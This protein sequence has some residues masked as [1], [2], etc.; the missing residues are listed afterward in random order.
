MRSVLRA[1]FAVFEKQYGAKRTPVASSWSI[2][3]LERCESRFL[4]RDWRRLST[5]ETGES[6]ACPSIMDRASGARDNTGKHVSV[7]MLP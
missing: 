3:S 5:R 1:I 2:S 6:L 4:S 7:I